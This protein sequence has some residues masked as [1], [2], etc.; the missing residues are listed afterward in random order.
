MGEEIRS[1]DAAQESSTGKPNRKLIWRSKRIEEILNFESQKYGLKLNF[2]G[3][4]SFRAWILLGLPFY[5]W[6]GKKRLPLWRWMLLIVP[7][8]SL[9]AGEMYNTAHEETIRYH[10]EENDH[11]DKAMSSAS[12]GVGVKAVIAL[13]CALYALFGHDPWQPSTVRVR[14]RKASR[15]REMMRATPAPFGVVAVLGFAYILF[16]KASQSKP[17]FVDQLASRRGSWSE[18]THIHAVRRSAS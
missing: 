6:A 7:H 16:G 3:E 9:L 8:L 5:L 18:D 15:L 11:F 17:T 10:E 12:V 1:A 2:I 14:R 4:P 13:L